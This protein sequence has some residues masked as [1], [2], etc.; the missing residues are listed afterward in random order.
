MTRWNSERL[1]CLWCGQLFKRDGDRA[2]SA[3]YCKRTH[4][5]KANYQ[6]RIRRAWKWEG[7]DAP[8][9]PA[10]QDRG[11]AVA[12]IRDHG[13][14]LLVC[15]CGKYHAV[16]QGEGGRSLELGPPVAGQESA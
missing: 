16:D 10:E 7:C 11:M 13:G 9:A 1:L 3:A 14:E 15:K 5:A 8:H 2:S 4:R 6:R 12:Y